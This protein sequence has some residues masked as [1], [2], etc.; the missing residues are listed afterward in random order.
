MEQLR[1]YRAPCIGLVGG[2]VNSRSP[3]HNVTPCT[4]FATRVEGLCC[5][6][7]RAFERSR[8]SRRLQVERSRAALGIFTRLTGALATQLKRLVDST[9]SHWCVRMPL[10]TRDVGQ[11]VWFSSQGGSC[12]WVSACFDDRRSDLCRRCTAAP[13]NTTDN[14][15]LVC[16]S[17]TRPTADP[18]CSSCRAGLCAA[19]VYIS[20]ATLRARILTRFVPDDS[21]RVRLFT[22]GLT[23]EQIVTLW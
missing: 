8:C 17:A 3:D 14:A 1:G 10:W 4:G 15:I 18:L 6:S 20:L 13:P 23:R 19:V 11:S 21:F 22:I 16:T 2:L 9:R 5:P 7:R 12:G